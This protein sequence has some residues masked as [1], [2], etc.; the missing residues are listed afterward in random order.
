MEAMRPAGRLSVVC[1]LSALL[2]ASLP[3]AA[4][5]IDDV[6][7]GGW[8]GLRGRPGVDGGSGVGCGGDELAGLVEF[9]CS[10]VAYDASMVGCQCPLAG[11]ERAAVAL[12]FAVHESLDVC[13]EVILWKA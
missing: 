10:R 8:G 4:T 6:G 13:D 2:H 12:E 7:E 1:I 9:P 5:A 3:A 11:R